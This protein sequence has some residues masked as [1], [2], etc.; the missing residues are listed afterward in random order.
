[1]ADKSGPTSESLSQQYRAALTNAVQERRRFAIPRR[2]RGCLTSQPNTSARPDKLR[3]Q[4]FKNLRT[5]SAVTD[6]Q[7][8]QSTTADIQRR[9]KRQWRILK[10]GG[11]PK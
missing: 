11:S 5:S 4:K 3:R 2:V 9:A 6:D 10:R 1:M 8:V 7:R